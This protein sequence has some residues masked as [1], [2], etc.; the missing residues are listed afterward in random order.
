MTPAS[1]VNVMKELRACLA[2]KF[3]GWNGGSATWMFPSFFLEVIAFIVAMGFVGF[4][5]VNIELFEN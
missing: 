2:G 1:D 3:K 5:Q 4:E